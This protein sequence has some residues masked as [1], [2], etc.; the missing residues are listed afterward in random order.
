[1]PEPEQQ[2]FA[3]PG[4]VIDNPISGERIVIRESGARNGGRLLVFDLYLP[5]GAH[6]PARHVH[7][8]QEE[9]FTVVAGRMRFRVG[10][11]TLMARPGDTVRVPAGTAHWFGNAGPGTS[12]ARVEARPA[13]RLEEAFEAAAVMGRER[14]YPGTRLPRLTDLALYMLEYRRELATPDV[15]AALVRAVLTPLAWLGRRRGRAAGP[16]SAG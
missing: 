16:G 12:H 14:R 6:V 1:M 2:A 7:P 3:T 11:R 13:L 15:P 9:Q 5:P 8:A 4:R 10:R